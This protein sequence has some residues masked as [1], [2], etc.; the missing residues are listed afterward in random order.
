ML[1]ICMLS[2][3]IAGTCKIECQPGQQCCVCIQCLEVASSKLYGA[4]WT[5][6]ADRA[7]FRDRP[8]DK[9]GSLSHLTM[10]WCSVQ[11][12]LIRARIWWEPFCRRC[13][14]C[15]H[16]PNVVFVPYDVQRGQEDG[17][18]QQAMSHRWSGHHPADADYEFERPLL[19]QRSAAQLRRGQLTRFT[20]SLSPMTCRERARRPSLGYWSRRKDAAITPPKKTP[21]LGVPSCCAVSRHLT[22]CVV[23]TVRQP[24]TDMHMRG[25]G[26]RH[27]ACMRECWRFTC[28]STPFCC[29]ASN[30]EARMVP[31]RLSTCQMLLRSG[32]KQLGYAQQSCKEDTVTGRCR[33]T[34]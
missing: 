14:E 22:G 33:K 26:K 32:P 17:G 25:D 9:V 24:R 12:S 10:R 7:K 23:S 1:V 27:N 18:R 30:N 21:N 31:C 20:T 28:R 6:R 29:I 16:L 2:R 19:L 3:S 8:A 11:Y 13:Y 34:C 15:V 5:Y 4:G